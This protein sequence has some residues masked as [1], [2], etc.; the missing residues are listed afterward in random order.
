MTDSRRTISGMP[1]LQGV[2]L[3]LRAH[4]GWA[5]LVALGGRS[6]EPVVVERR[7]LRLCDDSFPRQPY[8]AAEELPAA[9]AEA[10]VARSLATANRLAQEAL[11]SAV[12]DLRAAG[13][14][15][16][17]AGLLL[18]SGRPLP[19][20]LQAIL[21]AHPLIHTAEGEMYRE[22]LRAGCERAS[23]PVLGFRERD[24]LATASTRLALAPE[25]LRARVAALGKPLGPPWRQ[26]EKLAALAAWQLLQ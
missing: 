12:K 13:R 23:I 14:E 1:K 19:A 5:V 25:T 17:R 3:G 6:V 24:I 9:R 10:L 20:E 21:A 7:R 18:S 15:V 4:S 2:T 26:D 22:A 8:H 16:A 11:A